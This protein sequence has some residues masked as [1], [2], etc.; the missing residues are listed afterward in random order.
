MAVTTSVWRSISCSMPFGQA[1]AGRLELAG[2]AGALTALP[3]ALSMRIGVHVWVGELGAA[4]SLIEEL[5]T[6]TEATGSHL[7][8]YGALALVAWQRREAE[9]TALI[10][11][12]LDEAAR[13]GEGIGVAYARPGRARPCPAALR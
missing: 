10:E 11:A 1:A 13:R 12:T 8:P 7:A 6:V 9:G 3:L 4:A 2:G 5:E